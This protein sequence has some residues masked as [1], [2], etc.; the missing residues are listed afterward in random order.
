[1]RAL[2]EEVEMNS[3][4]APGRAGGGRL[5]SGAGAAAAPVHVAANAKKASAADDDFDRAPTASAAAPAPAR[6]PASP[7]APAAREELR[8]ATP[9]A[10]SKPAG[11]SPSARADRLYA[12]GHWAEAA[13]AYRELLRRDPRNADAARWRQRLAAAEAATATEAPAATTAP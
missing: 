2:D 5:Q 11:E 3:G 12:E 1:K 7:P 6:P 13:R 8:R 9:K 4:P 10:E